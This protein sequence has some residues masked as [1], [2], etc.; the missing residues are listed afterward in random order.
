MNMLEKIIYIADYIEPGRKMIPALPEVRRLAF[1]DID[2]AVCECAVSTLE[3]LKEEGR[4]ID[5]MTVKTYK[6][7]RNRKG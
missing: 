4:P 5:P 7:Y 6:F 3:Y 2:E 1:T